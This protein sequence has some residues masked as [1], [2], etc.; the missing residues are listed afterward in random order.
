MGYWLATQGLG[1]FIGSLGLGHNMGLAS[2]IWVEQG[3]V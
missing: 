3:L 2:G 1:F